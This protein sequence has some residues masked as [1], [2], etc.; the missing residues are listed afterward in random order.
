MKRFTVTL[1]ALFFLL[2]TPVFSQ[3]RAEKRA[4]K[5]AAIKEKIESGTF[6]IIMTR[7][8]PQKGQMRETRD[9]Y[10]VEL[11]EG[12][13]FSCSL[14][15]IGTSTSAMIGG[16]DI[17]VS[18]KDE[19]V[20]PLKGYDEKDEYYVY[21][22]DFTNEG[23]KVEWKCTIVIFVNGVSRVI[24]ENYGRDSISYQGDIQMERPAKKKTKSK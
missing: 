3:T 21:S 22:F 11:K 23:I 16:Q 5:E 6:K 18:C 12:N 17:S 2:Q 8:F 14:P 13:I 10:Y 19:E 9:G 24:L 1:F 4:M 7:I 15:Y 20:T